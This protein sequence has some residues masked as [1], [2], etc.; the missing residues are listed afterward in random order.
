MQRRDGDSWVILAKLWVGSRRLA[1]ESEYITYRSN[2]TAREV[3][4]G[5]GNKSTQCALNGTTSGAT[6]TAKAVMPREIGG[7]RPQNLLK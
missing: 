6:A 4:G 1:Q 7:Q 3:R 2:M 5:S